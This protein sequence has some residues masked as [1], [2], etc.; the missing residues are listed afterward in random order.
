VMLDGWAER[1]P[2]VLYGWY[3]GMEGGHA[4]ARVLFG[5]VNPS[6]RLPFTIPADTAHLPYFSSTDKTISYDLYHGYSLLDKNG[7]KPRYPFGFGLSYTTFT[8]SDLRVIDA[9]ATL[10]VHVVVSNNGKRVGAEVVQV[11]VGMAHPEQSVV[12]RQRKLL[13]GFEKVTIAPGESQAVTIEVAKDG[14]RYF[15]VAGQ[16]WVLE[17]G[18]YRV[19]V[20]PYADESV[21][22]ETAVDLA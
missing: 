4:L 2:A 1:T 17:A 14:L 22:L 18:R 15:D 3:S 9:G 21:L 10:S 13:Q 11:Y 12:A 6:G 20:G 16:R 5:D 7:H 8:Y 19:L